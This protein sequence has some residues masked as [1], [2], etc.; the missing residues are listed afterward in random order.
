M[1]TRSGRVA[2]R[3]RAKADAG[4]P[5]EAGRYMAD[6]AV[7]GPWLVLGKDGRLSVYAH[8]RA[9]LLRWTEA[10][11]GGS[12][13]TGPDVFPAADLTRVSVAQGADGYIH[14]LGRREVRKGTDRPPSTSS[15]PS[16]TR[17]TA[18]SRSGA[19]SATR[20]RTGTRRRGSASRPGR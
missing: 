4:A 17:P 6:T 13:W 7:G 15:T 1:R 5:G 16:S 18:P 19:R 9:G 12:R 2:V 3:G 14:F 20:T 11:R 8:G 10:R